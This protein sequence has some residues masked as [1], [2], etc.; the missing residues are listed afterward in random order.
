MTL[1]ELN[2]AAYEKMYAELEAFIKELQTSP[3]GTV[4]ELAY[5]LVVKEDMLLSLEMNDLTAAQCKALLKEKKPL[6]KLFKAWENSESRHMDDIRDCIEAFA[7]KL[8]LQH[9]KN[10]D[11]S[12]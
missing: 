3:P 7:D 6:D 1:E 2:T 11:I 5:E 9:R 8:I 10:R 12:R 4:I